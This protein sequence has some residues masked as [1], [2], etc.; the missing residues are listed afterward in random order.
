MNSHGINGY[1]EGKMD[2]GLNSARKKGLYQGCSKD[3]HNATT[4][5]LLTKEYG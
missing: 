4:I 5:G 2:P 1:Y 3:Y